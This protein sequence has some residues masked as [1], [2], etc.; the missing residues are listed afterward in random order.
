MTMSRQD[1][2]LEEILAELQA[3]EFA[4]KNNDWEP[5]FEG[6]RHVVLSKFGPFVH[7]S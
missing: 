7:D 6:D 4:L 3:N 5:G 2:P 1:F